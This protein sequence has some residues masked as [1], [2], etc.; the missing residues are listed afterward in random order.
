MAC[1][2]E[3]FAPTPLQMVVD[4]RDNNADIAAGD[5]NKVS[6]DAQGGGMAGV[7]GAGMLDV[8]E[9]EGLLRMFSDYSAISAGALSLSAALSGKLEIA[10]DAIV[11]E[12]TSKRFI[13]PSRMLI[14]RAALNSQMTREMI[15]D[16]LGPSPD[17]G[18]ADFHIGVTEIPTLKPVA[19]D[20]NQED[21]DAAFWLAVTAHMPMAA[22]PPL[23]DASG[24][25]W[26]DGGLGWRST[27]DLSRSPNV[28]S[29]HNYPPVIW[30]PS[31]D[32]YMKMLASWLAKQ[33]VANPLS[34]LQEMNTEQVEYVNKLLM[35]EVPSHQEITPDH[36][37]SLP[38]TLCMDPNALK[39]GYYAGQTA[40]RT[41]IRGSFTQ[42]LP[43]PT[44][45]RL[46]KAIQNATFS[47]ARILN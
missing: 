38:D 24:K 9:K 45:S 36:L 37:S 21:V 8:L 28:L 47:A 33:G 31:P 40:C 10:V 34:R 12:L 35:G 44:Q 3:K 1:I 16:I 17:L 6:L 22:G 46:A 18:G 7:I 11:N 41:A 5:G 19:I 14:G 30:T 2:S 13:R 43:A 20:M 15:I 32:S 4:N 27:S 23:Q 26:L 39:Q 29:L 42:I 25:R